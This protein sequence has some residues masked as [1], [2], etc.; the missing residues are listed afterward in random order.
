MLVV[1]VIAGV[2]SLIVFRLGV[3]ADWH[4]GA[5][6]VAACVPIAFAYFGSG[7]GLLLSIAFAAAIYKAT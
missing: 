2:I 6:L 1:L 7:L 4:W 3:A 5:A